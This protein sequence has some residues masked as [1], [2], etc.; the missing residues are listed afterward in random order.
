L[1]TAF[2]TR[3]PV[4]KFMKR[5][6]VLSLLLGMWTI[7]PGAF[8]QDA[9]PSP[10][11][12]ANSTPAGAATAPGVAGSGAPQ[13]PVAASVAQVA[14]GEVA[15]TLL[16]EAP[17]GGGQPRLR[18]E[19]LAQSLRLSVCR[20]ACALP[21]AIDV[22]LPSDLASLTPQLTV[23]N[24]GTGRRAIH[25]RIDSAERRWEAIALAPLTGD[26][27]RVVFAGFTGL[28]EGEE[29]DRTGTRVHLF[30]KPKGEVDVVVGQMQE[31]V[32][33]CGRE[34]LLTP[35]MVYAKDL[36]LHRI[37]LQRLPEAERAAAPVLT[38]VPGPGAQTRQLLSTRVAS[39]SVGDPSDL[40][41]GDHATYWSEERSGSGSG[42]FVVMRAQ[43]GIDMTGFEFT[44]RPEVKE[45]AGLIAPSAFWIATEKNVYRVQVPTDPWA[46]GDAQFTVTLP[47]PI[48]AS[49]VALV[50]D[51]AFGG[52][53]DAAVTIADIA[54]TTSLDAAA[55]EQAVSNLDGEE[56]KASAA[57]ELLEA[58]GDSALA[59]VQPRF[60]ALSPTG[61]MRALN[62]YDAASC[63]SSAPAYVAALIAPAASSAPVGVDDRAEREHI[64][65]RLQQCGAH[66]VSAI[67]AA[68][69]NVKKAGDVGSLA[70]TLADVAPQQAVENLVPM[71]SKANRS[72]R[73]ALREA[74]YAAVKVPATHERVAAWLKDASLG[75]VAKIDLLRALG[76]QLNTLRE[77]VQ[78]ALETLLV[79]RA[80]FRTRYTLLEPLSRAAEG[81][82]QLLTRLLAL[83]GRDREPAV[84]TQ[85]A[86]LTPVAD[87][88]LNA[89]ISAA[90]DPEPRVRE[91]AIG[92]LG[93]KRAAG[94]RMVMQL[95][96]RED[97]WPFVRSAA[98]R[99]LADLPPH[100]ET[101][102]SLALTVEK[103]ASPSVRRPAVLALGKLAAR[104]Q[105]RVIRATYELDVD[106]SVRAAAVAVLGQLCDRDQLDLI[107]K[108][109]VTLA[110]LSGSED[111]L[112]VAKA[113]LGALGRLAPGDLKQRLAPFFTK[114]T[115]VL[116]R[117]AAQAALSTPSRC[118]P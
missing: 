16:G 34:A 115:P 53:K 33:L 69:P 9:Q 3:P 98:V 107:T 38:A 35:Q 28:T 74:L 44:L 51:T 26:A 46:G 25:L 116:S 7:V 81:N 31:D 56:S 10:P 42:E 103:D 32:Q 77:P 110:T 1:Y 19:R 37:K 70:R 94:G 82:Q 112:V 109:A 72:K 105:L 54:P 68:L 73:R 67:L 47:E 6:S 21:R 40:T 104:D 90:R 114:T 91:A 60:G 97:A 83:L 64:A 27:P 5:I 23:L 52:E 2:P 12:T 49:C 71:L 84:R 62:V 99:G 85:A 89:L 24:L 48:R 55:V 75:E 87:A 92:N 43:S 101:T 108:R 61:R 29:P 76:A 66:S 22:P 15:A 58:L 65:R 8:A 80:D 106:A 13:G 93:G 79:E 4:A 39:S 113:S 57:M 36:E 20:R 102:S 41:D 78:V 111:D 95:Q 86:R 18:V 50:L 11:S 63:V 45:R 59:V 96:L 88:S 17:A 30:N 14:P 117:A 118:Q 100:P